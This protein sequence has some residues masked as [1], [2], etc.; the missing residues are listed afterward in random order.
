MQFVQLG[1][2]VKM[3]IT[4]YSACVVLCVFCAAHVRSRDRT[5][6][7]HD[8][9]TAWTPATARRQEVF[10][11]TTPQ[12]VISVH[13][14]WHAIFQLRRRLFLAAVP[15]AYY[16][17]SVFQLGGSREVGDK[18]IRTRR[19][20]GDWF[21]YQRKW[22]SPSHP[23]PAILCG[24]LSTVIESKILSQSRIFSRVGIIPCPLCQRYS[25]EIYIIGDTSGSDAAADGG[26]ASAA[27]R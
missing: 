23:V 6:G 3:A 22:Q 15:I 20:M 18:V 7:P 25:A 19:A 12:S 11:D 5:H 10:S 16:T 1:R 8:D 26:D 24:H 21:T 14:R 4:L 27:G 17:F 13:C 9:L 2:D